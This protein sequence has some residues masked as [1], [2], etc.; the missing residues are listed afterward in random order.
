MR[1]RQWIKNG[2]V[3]AA[4]IFAARLGHLADV[5]RAVFAFLLFCLICGAIYLLNDLVDLD[6]DR[7]HPNKRQRPIASGRVSVRAARLT[8]VGAAGVGLIGSV[9]LGWSFFGIA[10]GYVALMI[11]YTFILKHLVLVDAL[12]IAGGFV[13]RAWAG[14]AA[15]HVSMSPWLYLA[16]ILIALFLAFGKRRNEILLL[17]D[18]AGAHRRN[19]EEYT[20][21]LLD[22][23]ITITAAA[24]IMTYGLYTFF[25]P[26]LPS[27]HAMMATVPFVLYG[28]FRYLFL[29]HRRNV[30]GAP[31][32]AILRD[33]PLLVDLAAWVVASIVILYWFK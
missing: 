28:I 9:V 6:V 30:T 11:A 4:L 12:T 33:L 21:Q 26:D 1:P 32:E 8:A 20:P 24:T 7:Q 13:L 22:E 15:I 14:A 16:T 27:N 29:I 2:F 25:A 10:A 31:E 17:E 5:G 3:F 23:L 19:L 18:G